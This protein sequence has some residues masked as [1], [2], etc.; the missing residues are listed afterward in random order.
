[1][2][3][4]MS[5]P[6]ALVVSAALT[7]MLVPTGALMSSEVPA[8]LRFPSVKSSQDRKGSGSRPVDR[9]AMTNTM[10]KSNNS[11]RMTNFTQHEPEEMLHKSVR[12]QSLVEFD[13]RNIIQKGIIL[14]EL[15]EELEYI[16]VGIIVI[17]VFLI[18]AVAFQP[19][20]GRKHLEEKVDPEF[21]KLDE[22][23]ESSS[24]NQ[25]KDFKR[26]GSMG[27]SGRLRFSRQSI[28]STDSKFT[29]VDSEFSQA[30]E[31]AEVHCNAVNTRHSCTITS[32]QAS[33]SGA[34]IRATTTESPE[35][36]ALGLPAKAKR[37][38]Y[39]RRNIDDIHEHT[40][41]E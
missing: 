28:D 13:L 32:F 37:M 11:R 24:D 16:L 41:E 36:G 3:F 17:L 21:Y 14:P 9:M 5:R 7:V 10:Q 35:K 38:G 26:A 18:V 19:A 23:S 2:Q 12:S 29:R 8:L 25:H 31:D 4:S 1:M 39:V 30:D 20:L 22:S 6:N 40:D 15:S 34:H 33:A 27:Q